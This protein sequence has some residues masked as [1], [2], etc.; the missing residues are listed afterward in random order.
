MKLLPS[1]SLELSILEFTRIDRIERWRATTLPALSLS[2]NSQDWNAVSDALMRL[3]DRRVLSI[4]KWIEPQ[5]FVIAETSAKIT[6]FL[7]H[8]EFQLNITPNGRVYTEA[9]QQRAH[10]EKTIAQVS[11][12]I[13]ID[14]LPG[15]KNGPITLADEMRK[16]LLRP[17]VF[18]QHTI[19]LAKQLQASIISANAMEVALSKIDLAESSL[20]KNLFD[21]LTITD[22]Q[23]RDISALAVD[24]SLKSLSLIGADLAKQLEQSSKAFKGLAFPLTVDGVSKG[25]LDQSAIIA[26]LSATIPD[27]TKMYWPEKLLLE[28]MSLVEDSV[29]NA[30]ALEVLREEILQPIPRIG[31]ETIANIKA[32]TQFVEGH[33]QLVRALPPR[34]PVDKEEILE[35]LETRDQEIGAKLESELER[36]GSR[37]VELRR[38]AWRNFKFNNVAGARVA[39]A[40]IRELYSEVM[41]TLVSDDEVMKTDIWL[42]RKP[43]KETKPTRRMRYQFIVGDRLPE[44]DALVQFDRSVEN[45]N[46]FTH[47]FSDD[48]EIVRVSI[49]QIETCLYLLLRFSNRGR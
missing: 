36:L 32:A 41:R 34:I 22:I 19:D 4:R 8:G 25:F 17:T 39:M 7:N 13:N 37:Y 33:V 6:E 15:M 38:I 40:G 35:T 20:Y 27:L 5:G 28:R 16:A 49:T 14:L 43:G 18:E 1:E 11:G 2:V 9:L 47:T 21:N 46:K 31:T 42:K 44:F 24:P 3:H 30:R 26:G 48:P 12:V 10:F 23:F 29:W 45:A